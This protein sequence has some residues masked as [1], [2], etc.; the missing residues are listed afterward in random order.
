MFAL[1]DTKPLMMDSSNVIGY[2]PTVSGTEIRFTNLKFAYPLS[3]S[4]NVNSS[5][6][7]QPIFNGLTLEIGEGKTVA[8]VGSSGCGKSTILRLLYRF[9]D[10]NRGTL[11]LGGR[12]IRD[13][14]SDSVRRAIAVVP[15]DTVLFNESILY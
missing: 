4:N 9:Y 3:I 14:T 6:D 12:D 5:E 8:L 11:F 7:P 15:Q 1:K 10:C 2:D 13:Y